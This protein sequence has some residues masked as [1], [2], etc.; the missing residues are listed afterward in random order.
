MKTLYYE[1]G[2]LNTTRDRACIQGEFAPT[3]S[4]PE[5]TSFFISRTVCDIYANKGGLAQCRASPLFR[6]VTV[7]LIDLKETTSGVVW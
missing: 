5:T 3:P 2:R 4:P 7:D 6:F 1:K